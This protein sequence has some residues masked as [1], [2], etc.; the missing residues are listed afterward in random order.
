MMLYIDTIMQ[1]IY[2]FIIVFFGG[3]II[4]FG[5]ATTLVLFCNPPITAVG[6]FPEHLMHGT[7]TWV[8]DAP[9]PL[10]EFWQR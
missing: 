9:Q 10:I 5:T 6:T 7:C 4:F 3:C 2:K 1:A 8:Y